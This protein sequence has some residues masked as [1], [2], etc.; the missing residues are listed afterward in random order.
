M[1]LLSPHSLTFC[2]LH[3]VV[4]L[5]FDSLCSFDRFYSA[6]YIRRVTLATLNSIRPLLK[7][8]RRKV[9]DFP[10][11]VSASGFVRNLYTDF[12]GN[13]AEDHAGYSSKNQNDQFYGRN[14]GEFEQNQTLLGF[15]GK[16]QIGKTVNLAPKNCFTR[17]LMLRITRIIIRVIKIVGFM[18]EI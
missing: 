18:A 11:S 6:M 4:T 13:V 10:C 15:T 8:Y 14:L 1:Y 5:N 9:P 16:A 2:C 7:V 17:R 12:D 3:R